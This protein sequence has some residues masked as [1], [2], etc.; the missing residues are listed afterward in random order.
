[1][2]GQKDKLIEWR[3]A[4]TQRTH[5]LLDTWEDDYEYS[6]TGYA[7]EGSWGGGRDTSTWQIA[8]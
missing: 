2:R 7:E 4:L 3:R 1:M 5:L 8:A 6:S